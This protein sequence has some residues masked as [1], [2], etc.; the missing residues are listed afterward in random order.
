MPKEPIRVLQVIGRL[1]MGGVQSMLMNYYR[2]IDRNVI[3]F[4]FVVQDNKPEFFDNE[5]R[6]LG[7]KIHPVRPLKKLFAFYIDLARVLKKNDYDIIHIHQNF[8]SVHAL[9]VAFLFSV[10]KR[11]VHS[12][13]AYPEKSFIKRMTKKGITSIINVLS[14]HRFACSKVAAIW[15]YG[16]KAVE[17]NRTKIIHNAISVERFKFN[18]DIRQAKRTELGVTNDFTIGHIGHL[19]G[20]K[21]PVFLIDIFYEISKL[22]NNVHLL[23]IGQ[24]PL[25]QEIK[26]K[27][28]KLGLNDKVTLL[29]TRSD[30][31]EMLSAFDAFVFPSLY[32][33]LGIVVVE[34][35]AADLKCFISDKV[36]HEV[37]LTELV[38]YIPLDA[39]AKEWAKTILSK[40]D[41]TD[42]RKDMTKIIG[43]SGYDIALEARKLQGQYIKMAYSEK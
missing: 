33:G 16:V 38:T 18:A 32:E 4:D 24:G 3:Q 27:V 40:A 31:N 41:L 42:T 15:L 19:S 28:E 10:K 35:Q 5:I 20:Q 37:A 43:Q 9:I 8:A 36:T 7:G 14:T 39:S 29:G 22:K 21:N 23:L 26:S 1:N 11:I 2:H 12:H 13:N 17:K 30:V 25:E 34:A 6:E